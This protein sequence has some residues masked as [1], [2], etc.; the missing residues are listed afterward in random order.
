MRKRDRANKKKPRVG[1][2]PSQGPHGRPSYGWKGAP[3]ILP[4]VL[5]SFHTFSF[6]LWKIRELPERTAYLTYSFAR[7][8]LNSRT[9]EPLAGRAATSKDGEYERWHVLCRPWHCLAHSLIMQRCSKPT[10]T[11]FC[12]ELRRPR[13]PL[14]CE[15]KNCLSPPQTTLKKMWFW[16]T[17]C[18]PYAHFEIVSTPKRLLLNHFSADDLRF[19]TSP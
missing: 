11:R 16:T 13:A 15:S 6:G 2:R 4:R 18:T 5:P 8:G 1:S 19:R 10:G 3:V 14:F 9:P 17:H 12:S 7:S